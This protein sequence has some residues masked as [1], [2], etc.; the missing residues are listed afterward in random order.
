MARGIDR[1]IN[2]WQNG[3]PARDGNVWTDGVT[4]YSYQM[5]I[6][7]R[8]GD[9]FQLVKRGPTKTTS[10]HINVVRRACPAKMIVEVE[11]L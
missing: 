4:I 3:N 9:K 8:V 7:R 10:K 2:A 6:G 1:V 5:A 11:E